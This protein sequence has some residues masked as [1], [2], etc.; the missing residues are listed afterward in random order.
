MLFTSFCICSFYLPVKWPRRYLY[1]PHLQNETKQAI[2]IVQ[3]TEVTIKKI[4]RFFNFII[5]I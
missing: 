4:A 2:F 3:K 5:Y 1:S